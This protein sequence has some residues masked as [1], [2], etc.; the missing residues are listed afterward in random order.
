MALCDRLEA[1]RS[2]REAA[3]DWLA[4][5]SLDRLNALDA[6][7]FAND[8]R[9]VL[10][11][12]PAIS[13]TSSQVAAIR[14]TILNLAV[15]GK[16]VP[17]QA[18]D[19]IAA[20]L[21]ARIAEERLRLIDAGSIPRPKPA[22]RDSSWLPVRLPP[23]WAPAALGDLCSL[24]T[25]GSRGWGEYYA[26]KG[27]GFVRAQNIRFGHLRLD[28][29]A[30]VN[31]PNKSEGSRTRVAVGDL[32]VV[33]TGAGVT[34]PALLDRD[35]GE[36]YVSQHVALVRPVDADLSQWLLLCL[37][38]P[39]GG[40]AELVERAYGSG[41]PGLNLD[42]LRCLSVPI[43][44]LAE[45]KRIVVKVQEL[46]ALCD[47]LEASLNTAIEYRFRLLEA[48]L[49]GAL[50]SSDRVDEVATSEVPTAA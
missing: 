32:L 26:D 3:R 50:E 35:I 25:S 8:T 42:N 4:A 24:V 36:A 44:P 48:V 1:A 20:D 30:R 46:M 27:P 9:F 22:K 39:S 5:A 47:Q 16:L 45:Q 34:N 37:M 40:R 38:A 2:E 49:N 10:D 6:E 12:L 19:Q 7:T 18:A 29:L 13:A 21:L 33:I 31:P 15:S 11:A 41:K 17:H 43:P 14:Q 23:S 28:D